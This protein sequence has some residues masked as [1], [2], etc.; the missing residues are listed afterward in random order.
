MLAKGVSGMWQAVRPR[1]RNRSW[2]RFQRL[3]R[4]RWLLR[5]VRGLLQELPVRASMSGR[6][7]QAAVRVRLHRLLLERILAEGRAYVWRRA[8]AGTPWWATFDVVNL[9]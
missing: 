8:L 1:G 5:L 2:G 7:P 4:E 3:L 6:R 9:G